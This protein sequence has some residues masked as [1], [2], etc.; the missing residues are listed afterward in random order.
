MLVR[1]LT[2]EIIEEDTINSKVLNDISK[3][4]S[5]NNKESNIDKDLDKEISDIFN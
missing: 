4:N 5:D 1:P 3:V 2:R